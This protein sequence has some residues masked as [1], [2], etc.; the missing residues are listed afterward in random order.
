[1]LEPPCVNVTG[2]EWLGIMWSTSQVE[3]E[4]GLRDLFS[5]QNALIEKGGGD[6]LEQARGLSPLLKR[7]KITTKYLRFS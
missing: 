3:L 7:L 4:A 2:K 1:M 5:V 6:R